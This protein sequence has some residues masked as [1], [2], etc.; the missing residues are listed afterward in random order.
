MRDFIEC[1]LEIPN[2]QVGLW[3]VDGQVLEGRNKPSVAG[4]IFPKLCW[5]ALGFFRIHV[6]RDIAY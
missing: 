1:L 6:L 4:V 2:H 5:S 3:G